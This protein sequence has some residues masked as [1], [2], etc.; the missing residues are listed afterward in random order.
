MAKEVSRVAWRQAAPRDIEVSYE[1]GQVEHVEG[2]HADAAK[3]AALASLRQVDSPLGTTLWAQSDERMGRT[4]A[5]RPTGRRPKR[6][7]PWLSH[8]EQSPDATR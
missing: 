1:D 6:I 3:L 2:S 7:G 4:E 5:N 8:F